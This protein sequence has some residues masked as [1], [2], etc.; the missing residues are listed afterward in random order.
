MVLFFRREKSVG[1]R[2]KHSTAPLVSVETLTPGLPAPLLSPW[3]KAGA[4]LPVSISTVQTKRK[5][6]P[7]G[8]HSLLFGRWF[9]S[10]AII[11]AEHTRAET[12]LCCKKFRLLGRRVGKRGGVGWWPCLSKQPGLWDAAEISPLKRGSSINRDVVRKGKLF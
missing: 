6:F 2:Q 9:P 5:G 7:L 11:L 4:A 12:H 3:R 10:I 8:S 1:R